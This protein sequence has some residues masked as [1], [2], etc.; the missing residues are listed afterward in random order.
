MDEGRH[1]TWIPS[2]GPEMRGGTAH[3]TVIISAD[4]IGSP[5]VRHPSAVIAM[6]QPS[7]EKYAPRVAAGG[8]LVAEALAAHDAP[9][10]PGLRCLVVPANEEA[11]RLGSPKSANLVLLGALVATT[12]L[13]PLAALERA[14]EAHL[15]AHRRQLL[16]ANRQALRRGAALA[17]ASAMGA[18]A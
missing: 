7:L 6:N 15:P 11:E 9:E 4:E 12:Q 13:L 17:E 8:V 16:E 3:C 5:L 1:V 14:L 10:Y 2:Y 18:E